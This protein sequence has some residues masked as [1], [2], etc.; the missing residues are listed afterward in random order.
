MSYFVQA[1]C[2]IALRA[3]ERGF[4]SGGGVEKGSTSLD[5]GGPGT[6]IVVKTQHFQ[7][8]YGTGDTA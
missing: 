2:S 1:A 3:I 5:V 8:G 7:C 6:R 4:L